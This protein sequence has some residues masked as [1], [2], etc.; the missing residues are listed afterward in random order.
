MDYHGDK[1][2]S[3]FV[4]RAVMLGLSELLDERGRR[5]VSWVCPFAST[6]A[7]TLISL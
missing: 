5:M 2:C 7:S 4:H 6:L 1:S 3:V